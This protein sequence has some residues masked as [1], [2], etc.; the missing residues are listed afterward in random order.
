[1]SAMRD[2]MLVCGECPPPP[3]PHTHHHHC[4]HSHCNRY[5][6]R[7]Y[8]RST[9]FHSHGLGLHGDRLYVINHAVGEDRVDVFT[10][11]RN[12]ATGAVGMRFQWAHHGGPER[13]FAGPLAGLLNGVRETSS[14]VL[15]NGV[16]SSTAHSAGFFHCA[17][18]FLC[19][20]CSLQFV[21]LAHQ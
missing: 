8:P 4:N 14:H 9:V 6:H 17:V 20:A 21:S 11:F 13:F 19:A 15:S 5:H 2:A 18:L 1:M 7:R 12:V 3:P 16:G 10:L